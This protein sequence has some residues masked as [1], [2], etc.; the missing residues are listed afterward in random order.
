MK[1][2]SGGLG[3]LS[4]EGDEYLIIENQRLSQELKTFQ[5]QIQKV[6]MECK[7]EV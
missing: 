3:V 5:N 7:R 4:E 6:R 1:K 2:V